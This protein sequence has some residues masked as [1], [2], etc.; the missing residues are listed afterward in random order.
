MSCS[1]ERRREVA[2]KLRGLERPIFFSENNPLNVYNKMYDCIRE[3]GE[4]FHTAGEIWDRL[5]DLIEP[6]PE[7]TCHNVS[8]YGK[9]TTYEYTTFDFKCSECGAEVNADEMGLSPIMIDEEN[10]TLSYCPH[11]GAKVVGGK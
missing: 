10:I 7:R 5:A 11:C 3:D 4:Q 6:Q 9:N 2:Q 8:E 1:D